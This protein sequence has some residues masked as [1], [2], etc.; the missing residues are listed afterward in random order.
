MPVHPQGPKHTSILPILCPTRAGCQA[1]EHAT[2]IP[3]E[4][5]MQAHL[6][7][8]IL[9]AAQLTWARG[10]GIGKGSHP[11]PR[12]HLR[13]SPPKCLRHQ[14]RIAETALRI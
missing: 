3:Q 8:W 10:E 13:E 9:G 1:T 5:Y 7:R 4:G 14:P 12:L 2:R 6:H 11:G